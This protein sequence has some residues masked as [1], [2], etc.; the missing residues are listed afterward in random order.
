[1]TTSKKFFAQRQKKLKLET[2]EI[3]HP[4]IGTHRYVG[5][6]FNAK[7]LTLKSGQQLV[8]QPIQAEF[9][10]PSMSEFSTLQMSVNIG[11]VGSQ[12]KRLLKDVDAYN[13][14]TPNSDVMTFVYRLFIDGFE[15][16]TL[17]MWVSN[18]A[19]EGQSVAIIASDDNPAAINVSERYTAERFPGLAVLS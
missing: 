10:L 12:V 11:R 7:T 17:S 19:I 2:F 6:Q 9:S 4:A 5:G 1:M 15:S 13:L 8:Y 18:I 16:A 3:S 14:A